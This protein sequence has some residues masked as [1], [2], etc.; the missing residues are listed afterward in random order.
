MGSVRLVEGG[1]D[2]AEFV[3]EGGAIGIDEGFPQEFVDGDPFFAAF[4]EGAA[5]DFPAVEVEGG[6]AVAEDAGADGVE[7]AGDGLDPGAAPG[8]VST[9]DGAET[10]FAFETRVG[11]FF[12]AAKQGRHQVAVDID[13]EEARFGDLL[14]AFHTHPGFV[15]GIVLFEQCGLAFEQWGSAVADQATGAAAGF[16]VAAEVLRKH[17]RRDQNVPDSEDGRDVHRKKFCKIK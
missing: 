7:T 6:Q 8:A 15:L 10:T 5:A 13:R 16:I 3:V 1:G 12:A 2:F 17:F 4:F 9:L 11:A 14:P